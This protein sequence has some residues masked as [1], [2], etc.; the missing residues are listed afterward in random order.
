MPKKTTKQRSAKFRGRE[1]PV[2]TRDRH[3]SA[4]RLKP[5]LAEVVRDGGGGGRF[6]NEP[7]ARRITSAQR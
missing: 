1:I 2:G 5:A 7:R 3:F 6:R 4:M